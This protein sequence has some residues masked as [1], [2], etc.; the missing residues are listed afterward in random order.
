MRYGRR[1]LG[2]R[3]E[4][5]MRAKHDKKGVRFGFRLGVRPYVMRIKAVRL[6]GAWINDILGEQQYVQVTQILNIY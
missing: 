3:D 4:A 1:V 5:R 2:K 6:S